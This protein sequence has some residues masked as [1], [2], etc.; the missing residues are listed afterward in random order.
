LTDN[1]VWAG[2]LSDALALAGE[3]LAEPI[4]GARFRHLVAQA[5]ISRGL[6]FPP[7]SEPNLR[8]AE[9]VLRHPSVVISL[10]RAGQ[11]MLIAPADRPDLLA[12]KRGE[13]PLTGIR[14]DFFTAFTRINPNRRPWYDPDLDAIAWLNG[15]PDVEKLIPVT[16]PTLEDE[17]SVRS[18][19]VEQIENEQTKELLRG[20]LATPQPLPAFT[21][22]VRAESLQRRWHVF[23]TQ[24]LAERIRLWAQQFGL[25][26]RDQWLNSGSQIKTTVRSTGSLGRSDYSNTR[27]IVPSEKVIQGLL[28]LDAED[29]ARIS[30]PL[31]LV[32]KLLRMA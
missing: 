12:E 20:A 9:L 26:W 25:H 2:V 4:L 7:E 3:N 21:A 18:R 30:V 5:A 10:A 6:V 8:L 17:L 23:R 16:S 19:F 1:G 28:A 15:E 29:L 31:D 14:A 27:G 24:A 32:L 13:G 11:D 22:I